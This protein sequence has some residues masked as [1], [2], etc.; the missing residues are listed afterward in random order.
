MVVPAVGHRVIARVPGRHAV[1]AGLFVVTF[2][3]YAVTI[4]TSAWTTDVYGAN[5]TSWHIAH[6][7]APWVDGESVRVLDV[8]T[9]SQ[10]ALVHTDNGHTAFA[11]FPGVVVAS[12][13]AYLL[14]DPDS[15]SGV[16]GSLMAA[17]LTALAVALMF[18][19]LRRLLPVRQALLA[20]AVFGLATPM[21]TV[22]AHNMWPHTIT[23]LGISGMAWAASSD[24]W[25]LAG[26]FGGVALWG[27]LHAVVVVAVLGLGVGLMRR[28]LRIVVKSALASGLWLLGACAWNQWVYGTWSPLGGYG[29]RSLSASTDYRYSLTNQLGMWFSADRGILVWTPIILLMVPA[30]VRSWRDLPDWSKT[31]VLGGFAYTVVQASMVTFT[32]GDGFYGYRYG[33]EFLACATPALALSQAQLGRVARL[34]AGPLIALQ[35]FAYLL[36]V[37][38]DNLD[39]SQTHVWVRNS[40]V[41]GLDQLGPLAWTVAGL[42]VVLGGY[43]AVRG[44][45]LAE[46]SPAK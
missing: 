29:G 14:S 3:I 11:R 5:W 16:P 21:W 24:R 4:P 25:W 8:R 19:A 32:G 41:H 40:F 42:V 18:S 44:P 10:L 12:V 22:S 2:I 46:L 35:A 7:G 30:L 1:T 9:D 6:T 37:S 20:V 27:R 31:L 45:Q 36:G 34:V 23:V 39:S 17:L 13:P 33:L 43:I 28:D 26:L 15:M 38:V